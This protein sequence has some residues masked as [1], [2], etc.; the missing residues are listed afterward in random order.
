MDELDDVDLVDEPN[1][2]QEVHRVHFPSAGAKRK[3]R[4]FPD[5]ASYS[6]NS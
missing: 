3:P 6:R 1:A 2:T 5:G 4:R